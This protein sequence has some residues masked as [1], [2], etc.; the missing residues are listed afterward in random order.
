MKN[1]LILSSLLTVTACAD[2]YVFNMKYLEPSD[3]DKTICLVTMDKNIEA[4]VYKN[5]FT[6]WLTSNGYKVKETKC[7]YIFGYTSSMSSHSFNV[8]IP[9]YGITG[10]NSINTTNNSKTNTYLQGQAYNNW[11]GNTYFDGYATSNTQSN[12][13]TNIDY[14]YGI[15]GFR[16]GVETVFITKFWSFVMNRQTNDILYESSVSIDKPVSGSDFAMRVMS[17]YGQNSMHTSNKVKYSCDNVGCKE[18]K[19]F[20]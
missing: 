3:K 4:T 5:F 12:S 14:N 13:T 7:K 11:R 10:I 18:S 16:Q 1:I 8:D 20:F 19:S 6:D 9:E 17:I 15:T 2:T